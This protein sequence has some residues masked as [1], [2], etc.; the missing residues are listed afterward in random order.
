MITVLEAINLSTEFL[1]K[2]NIQ[3]PRTNAELLLASA[4]KCKRLELYLSFDRPLKQNELNIYRK[5]IKRRSNFEPL[6]YITGSVEFYGLAFKVTPA[7]LI[8]RPETEILVEII[9]DEFKKKERLSILDIGCGSGIIGISL[10]VNLL[11]ASIFCTDISEDAINLAKENAEKHDVISTITFLKH[12]ILSQQIDFIQEA[13]AIVSNPPYVSK[14][15]FGSLQKEIRNFEPRY[16]VTDESDGYTFFRTISSKVA[17]ILKTGGKLFFEVS[18]GH[19]SMVKKIL[20]QNGF[21]E[22]TIIKDYQ[23]IDRVIYGAKI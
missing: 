13:D 2:K 12:N 17:K 22:I 19:S 21:V 7:V 10:A 18:E 3:S 16:A 8:P 6:Q 15:D 11:S 5:L 9:L 20:S 4:L 14:N 23:N 1:Q